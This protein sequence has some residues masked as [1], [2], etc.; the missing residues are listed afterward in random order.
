MYNNTLFILFLIILVEIA[1]IMKNKSINTINNIALLIYVYF[2][3][4]KSVVGYGISIQE[5]E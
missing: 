4:L 1:F 3:S 2:F 5:V